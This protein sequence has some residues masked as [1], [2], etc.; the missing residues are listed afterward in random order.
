MLKPRE[1]MVIHIYK[2]AARLPDPDYRR[3]LA[4]NSGCTSA[5]DRRFTQEGFEKVMAALETTLFARVRAGE[6][7]NPIGQNRWI[8]SETYW[9]DKLP[10][11]G[12]VNSRQIRKI[13]EL[14]ATL[15][16]F[17]DPERRTPAYFAGIVE[18]ATGKPD[19][20]FT[21]LS[22]YQAGNVI[23]ALNDRI[24]SAIR[25]ANAATKAE[26]PCPF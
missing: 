9:R 25:A 13:N 17:I 1:K 19:V 20:G 5:A 16:R 6:I 3:I 15:C 10:G 22:D 21:A 12:K 8:R 2:D 4:G 11:Y 24:K 26:E 23:D 14:W 18:H 7:P